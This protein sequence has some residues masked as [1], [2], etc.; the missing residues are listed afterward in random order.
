MATTGRAGAGVRLTLS[1]RGDRAMVANLFRTEADIVAEIVAHN[2]EIGERV[3][4]RA[5]VLAPVDKE[6][7]RERIK[8]RLS[9]TGLVFEVGY[10]ESDFAAAGKP[11]YFKYQEL[12]FTHWRSGEFI[13]NPHL[14]PAFRE[15]D[16]AYRA[17]IRARVQQ[18]LARR[19][20][21]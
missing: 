12:G 18:A 6:F 3:R 17:G 1:L 2:R 9:E 16:Q 11:P 13:R 20:A 21:G 15:F 5:F 19:R 4:E 8:L 10:D 7:M 14:E